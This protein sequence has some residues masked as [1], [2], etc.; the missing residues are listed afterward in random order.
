MGFELALVFWVWDEAE[1]GLLR[2]VLPPLGMEEGMEELARPTLP[3]CV[4]ELE[5]ELALVVLGMGCV[6]AVSSS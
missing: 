1:G 4:L 2:G 6:L 5:F 3:C